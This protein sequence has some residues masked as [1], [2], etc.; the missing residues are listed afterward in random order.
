MRRGNWN[1]L[2]LLMALQWA[3]PPP[4]GHETLQS[5]LQG[6]SWST[7]FCTYLCTCLPPSGTL[8][9]GP[10]LPLAFGCSVWPLVHPELGPPLVLPHFWWL[11]LVPL[12][13]SRRRDP[14]NP[15]SCTELPEWLP[16]SCLIKAASPLDLQG[17][18]PCMPC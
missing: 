13:F 7:L 6:S 5:S 11:Q 14:S 2:W 17:G 1:C 18:G 15:D 12:A 3:A 16:I 8:T 10:T 4:S 9:L